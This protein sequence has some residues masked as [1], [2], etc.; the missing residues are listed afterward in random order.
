MATLENRLEEV[1][2]D[3][4]DLDEENHSDS[5]GSTINCSDSSIEIRTRRLASLDK[6]QI[7][8]ILKEELKN[9][10]NLEGSSSSGPM[11]QSCFCKLFSN[12]V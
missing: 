1:V 3:V 4:T 10:L 8:D 6:P 2:V 7:I 12:E 11:N 5:N 9:Q